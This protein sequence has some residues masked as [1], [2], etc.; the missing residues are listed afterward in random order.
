MS[1]PHQ[2]PAAKVIVFGA[3]GRV[4]TEVIRQARAAGHHVTAF[5]RD[6]GKLAVQDVDIAVGDVYRPDTVAAALR[7]GFD[8]VIGAIGSDPLKPGTIVRDGTRAIISAMPASGNRRYLGVSG[9]AQ[10]PHT[11]WGGLTLAVLRRTPVGNAVEDHQFAYEE[12][13]RSGLDW[14]LAGCPYIRDGATRGR[15]TIADRFPGGFKTIHPGDVAAFLV[16]EITRHRFPRRIVG[17]WY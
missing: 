13:A 8:V 12:V 7:P 16:D 14:T 5:V 2:A 9:T 3:T 4:G 1:D 10:M 6:P 15:Y 11:R 17:I